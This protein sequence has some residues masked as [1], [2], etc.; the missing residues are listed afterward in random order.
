MKAI[1]A[2]RNSV[3]QDT[4]RITRVFG[5][6]NKNR[7]K[8]HLA[9]YKHRGQFVSHV[10]KDR[11][12]ESA[13]SKRDAAQRSKGGPWQHCG[14]GL[15]TEVRDARANGSR[16]RHADYDRPSEGGETMSTI[17]EFTP[18]R[19]HPGQASAQA[20]SFQARRAPRAFL[21]TTASLIRRSSKVL[22]HHVDTASGSLLSSPISSGINAHTSARRYCS[23]S[24][25]T[26]GCCNANWIV[27]LR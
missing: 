27:A 12:K 3:F 24:L 8:P 19:R 11:I 9:T 13:D 21:Y 22:H 2:P 25:R 5:I 20:T 16:G 6:S 1:L 26:S 23:K 4:Q 14:V 17:A 18:E 7:C 15:C 10:R